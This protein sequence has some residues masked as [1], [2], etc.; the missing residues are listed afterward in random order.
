MI[1]N[2]LIALVEQLTYLQTQVVEGTNLVKDAQSDLK[3]AKA[4][5]ERFIDELPDTIREMVIK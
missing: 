1:E 3:A 2:N 5:L 4:E